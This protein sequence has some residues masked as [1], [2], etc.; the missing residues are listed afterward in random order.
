MT[1]KIQFY[2]FIF[3]IYFMA[4][5]VFAQLPAP[6]G[7][8]PVNNAYAVAINTAISWDAVTDAASYTVT[9]SPNADLSDPV[10]QSVPGTSINPAGLAYGTI[11]YFTVQAFDGDG[12]PGTATSVFHFT[13]ILP[14]PV[15][16]APANGAVGVA[17][18]GSI[19]WNAVTN[20]AA[21]YVAFDTHSDMSAAHYYAVNVGTS[22]SP[23][24]LVNGTDYYFQVWAV[25]GG[26]G[27]GFMSSIYHFTT[28]LVNPVLV[29]PADAAVNIRVSTGATFTWGSVAGALSYNIYIATDNAFTNIVK[30]QT[31]LATTSFTSAA[32]DFSYSTGYFWK[33]EA[34]HGTDVTTSGVWQFTTKAVP[35]IAPVGLLPANGATIVPFGGS[36]SWDAAAGAASY[37]VFVSSYPDND[38]SAHGGSYTIATN[39]AGTSY[40]YTTHLL[41]NHTYYYQ[42][43]SV[44]ALG[45]A[46]ALSPITSFTVVI[47]HP[48]LVSPAASEGDVT[49]VPTLTWNS[50]AGAVTY[51]VY[52]ATDA[53]FA[54]IL[55]SQTGLAVTSFAIDPYLLDNSTTYYWRV[56]AV[57]TAAEI[58][59]TDA[60]FTTIDSVI[61]TLVNPDNGTSSY[62]YDNPV[63]T[64]TYTQNIEGIYATL[65]ITLDPTFATGVTTV[66]VGNYIYYYWP[67]SL[68]LG[69]TYYW[70]VY[71]STASGTIRTFSEIHSFTTFGT[72]TAP[73]LAWPVGGATV[74]TN[75]VTL[76]WYVPTGAYG[77]SFIYQYKKPADAA[78]SAEATTSDLSVALSGL[79][80][81]TTY[82]YRVKSY[83]GNTYSDWAEDSFITNGEGTITTPIAAWPVD[84]AMVYT[85]SPQVAWYLTENGSGLDYVVGFGTTADPA[86][87]T[88]QAPV[89][90]LYDVIPALTAGQSYFWAVKSVNSFGQ[91][92]AWSNVGSFTIYGNVTDIKPVLNFPVDDA[93]VY[94]FLPTLSWSA[95]AAGVVNYDVYCKKSTDAVYTLLT[96]AHT[97]LNYYAFTSQLT[98]GTVYDWYVVAYNAS[99]VPSTSEVGVFETVGGSGSLDPIII[100]PTDGVTSWTTTPLLKWYVSGMSAYP[101]TY[102]VE[103]AT[104]EA[105]TDLVYH[106]TDNPLIYS[107]PDAL[108]NGETYFWRVRST[109]GGV[110]SDWSSPVESFV[111]Y[112]D[113]AP[114]ELRLA[115]LNKGNSVN[116]LSPTLS[117]YKPTVSVPLTYN[118]QYGT[119]SDFSDA[120]TI[121]DLSKSSK[122]VDNLTAGTTYYWRVQS[123]TAK[124]VTSIFSNT[125]SFIANKVAAV[126]NELKRPTEFSLSQNYPNPF[127]PTTTISFGLKNESYV[128]LKVY[129][130]MGREV[131]TLISEN[132][133]AGMYEMQWRG[134]N[135][136][137]QSVASGMYL[138]KITAGNFVQVKKMLFLK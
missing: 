59:H 7:V 122:Q 17:L 120:V 85:T 31:G 116:T 75:D 50:V 34:V 39:V 58:T 30:S 20:A 26:G 40:D 71:T 5:N 125:G 23:S 24:G 80:P 129:D 9:V 8:T 108:G 21:Y 87:F 82:Q 12:N 95:G 70:R 44:D 72:A 41:N 124:G 1:R 51:N 54:H 130:M 65:Q 37:D 118:L 138:Y 28:A 121:S 132:R 38:P 18:D 93:T 76:S 64:W 84:D 109:A 69:K 77:L 35:P 107:I 81:G 68:L 86:S 97:D 128:T 63:F 33:V 135:N 106:V 57:K 49:V 101:V 48:V 83:N 6:T 126:A 123:K 27:G 74:Y 43:R 94:T 47:A 56:E 96:P 73:T 114:V 78:W 13:T 79:T 36:I 42:I 66:D 115:G 53:A 4:G 113:E 46:G 2:S 22:Y 104:D 11:Y 119:K 133:A 99:N 62:S 29:S 60:H 92:S 90:C 52:V 3:A 32:H 100:E 15:V 137:G 134:D 10:V 16:I 19:S 55:K 112:A 25:D 102:E 61:P 111:I 103:V 14:A 117:W 136:F 110:T 89:S 45:E 131:K 88:L 91:S 105:F 127:T 98:P 67:T